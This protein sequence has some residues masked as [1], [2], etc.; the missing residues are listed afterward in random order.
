MYFIITAIAA[1]VTTIICRLKG[2]EKKYKW[3]TLC[4]IYWGA[5]IMWFVDHIVTFLY[6]G[7]NFF[8]ISLDATLLGI[9]VVFCGFFAW[10]FILLVS[11]FKSNCIS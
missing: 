3:N 10:I 5:T 9:A 7:G 11:N 2:K 1:I 6:D 8:D 4:L